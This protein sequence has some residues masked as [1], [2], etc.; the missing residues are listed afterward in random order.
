VE[1]HFFGASCRRLSEERM[2]SVTDFDRPLVSIGLP[3]FNGGNYLRKAI[4]TIR[5]QT[6]PDFELIISDNASTDD[7]WQICTEAAAGDDRIRVI[8][9]ERNVGA[10]ANYNSVFRHARGKYFK[11]AAHDD[12]LAPTYVELAVAV[13][14]SDEGVVLCSTRTGR[15]NNVDQVTGAYASDS[16]WDSADPSRRF[17]SL[18][19]TPHACVAVFGLIRRTVLARTPLIAPYVNSDRVL[20]AELGLHGRI[21]EIDEELFFRRDHAGSSLRS[22]PDP[23]DRVVWFDPSR[24]ASFAF[25]EWNL[26]IGYLCAVG[27]APVSIGSRMRCLTAV[28]SLS[29]RTWRSLL[30]DFKYAAAGLISPRK[31]PG[32]AVGR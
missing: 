2:K 26:L 32:R 23:R 24:S 4:A 12:V 17:R 22:F 21:H 9:N 25:P 29:R 16:S 28:L 30:A 13:L 15:I 31:A 5:A 20:L 18:V 19:L 7:T 6:Y 14:E 1:V 27:R 10:A 8:R 11:W 3:V